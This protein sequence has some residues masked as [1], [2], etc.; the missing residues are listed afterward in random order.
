MLSKVVSSQDLRAHASLT[1]WVSSSA[2]LG[3]AVLRGRLGFLGVLLRAHFPLNLGS[4]SS[5][6]GMHPAQGAPAV[7]GGAVEEQAAVGAERGPASVGRHLAALQ[8]V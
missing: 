3:W 7:G 1:T 2:H 6:R 4:T 8:A 5:S